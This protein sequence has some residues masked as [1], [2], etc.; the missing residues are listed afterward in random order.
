MNTPNNNN[1]MTFAELISKHE[2]QIPVIQRDYVQGRAVT[3]EEK[4]K[5]DDFVKKTGHHTIS[6]SYMA[7][8]KAMEAVAS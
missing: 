1:A 2:V 3:D 6:T 7:A 8:E 5:R 4:E